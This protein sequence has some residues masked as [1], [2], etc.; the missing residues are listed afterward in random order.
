MAKGELK[1]RV[2]NILE[3]LVYFVLIALAVA[4][5]KQ[6]A[7]INSIGTNEKKI[8]VL[9]QEHAEDKSILHKRITKEDDKLNV[10]SHKV[11]A[12]EATVNFL[13]KGGP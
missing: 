7:K 8:E 6:N 9:R 12:I 1:T 2:N 3:K 13:L 5:F 11:S 4:A 10:V